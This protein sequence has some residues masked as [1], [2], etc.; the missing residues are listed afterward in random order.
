MS[1]K[2]N[3]DTLDNYSTDVERVSNAI[4]RVIKY[5]DT[6]EKLFSCFAWYQANAV[7]QDKTLWD[8]NFNHLI[9]R[10]LG[11]MHISQD[12]VAKLRTS[13][14]TDIENYRRQHSDEWSQYAPVPIG[15]F[16]E[17]V[18]EASRVDEYTLY[19][20]I[21]RTGHDEA[22]L[23]GN[24]LDTIWKHREKTL[25]INANL[26]QLDQQDRTLDF[27]RYMESRAKWFQIEENQVALKASLDVPSAKAKKNTKKRVKKAR[28]EEGSSGRR[29]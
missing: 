8:R 25:D 7:T 23:L 5:S 11:R 19:A 20:E 9:N 29:S 18:Q 6:E 17:A 28:M 21:V 24:V 12:F 15:E 22:V 3:L 27:S 4:K 1:K 10:E 13:L 16:I 26:T 2:L 14:D